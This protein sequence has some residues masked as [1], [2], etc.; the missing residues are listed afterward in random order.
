[1]PGIAKCGTTTLHD[2]LV[3]HTRVTGGIEK[4]VR[5][6]MDPDDELCPQNNIGS[7]GIEA[8]SSLYHDRGE[9]DFDIWL[10]AS[11]QYQYQAVARETI[12]QLDP[13]PKVLFI[14]RRPSQRLYS[15]YQYARYQHRALSQISSFGQFIDEVRS[16]QLGSFK[17]QRMLL[18]AWED[19]QYDRLVEQWSAILRPGNLFVTSVEELAQSKDD[20]LTQLASWLGIDPL[21]LTDAQVERSNPTTLTKSRLVR[22]YGSRLARL[23]PETSVMR[24]LKNSVRQL[25]SGQIDQSELQANAPL[26]AELDALFQP[27]MDRFGQLREAMDL[28]GLVS[29]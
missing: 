19:S 12:A 20:V 9:G 2:I 8:W 15:M 21:G 28:P 13:Q 11:P 1:M 4:E 29:G 3:A 16:P 23:L 26:L 14:V 24:K 25:N 7:S 17:R 6:L 18:N 5:F 10:D 22:K 27:H